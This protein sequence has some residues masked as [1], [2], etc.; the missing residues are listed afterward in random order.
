MARK[1]TVRDVDVR[2]KDVFVRVDFNVPLED[3]RITDDTRI[4]ETL[5]TIRYLLDQGATVILA[6]HLGRPKGQPV[7]S[8]RLTPVADRL[9]ELLGRP[10]KMA[11]DSVGPEVEEMARQLQPGEVL[12]LENLRFHP[13]EEENDPEFAKKLSSL[14]DIYVNDAFGSAHRAHASTAGIADYLP[15]VSG[16]LMAKELE[17]LGGVL[18]DPARPLVALIGGAKISTKIGVLQHLLD[19]ADQF[20]IGGGMANTLLKAEGKEVGASLVEEDKLDVA[21]D[22]LGEAKQKGRSVHLPIDVV[23]T[24]K[25]EQGANSEM[26]SA[27]QVPSG[28]M[29]VDIGPHTVEDYSGVLMNA[30]TVVWNGPMGIF[31]IPQFA[32]GTRAV[33]EALAESPAKTIVGGGDSV[34]AVEQAGLA[35]KMAHISTGGGASLEFLEGRELP[36]VAALDDA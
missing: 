33:A 19:L 6:S 18:D 26:V 7:D 2:G 24:Q 5:P 22:F 12:L 1:K 35:D 9:S 32:L 13:E 15:A 29:I 3:G 21:R 31:E 30:G 11:P 28:W 20:A 36:G 8:M 23:I 34:A 16:F 17:A 10:V 27:D 14:A 4:R 25:V